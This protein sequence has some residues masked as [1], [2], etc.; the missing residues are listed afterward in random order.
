MRTFF[1]FSPARSCENS[2]KCFFQLAF[3]KTRKIRRSEKE[4]EKVDGEVFSH[5][6]IKKFS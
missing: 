6:T 1:F 4:C 5:A 2:E 3:I